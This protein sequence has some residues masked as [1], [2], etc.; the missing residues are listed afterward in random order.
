[1]SW[2]LS[3]RVGGELAFEA[4]I[5]DLYDR[6]FSDMLIGFFFDG[7]DKERLIKS[8]MAYLSA[9]LGDR[10]GTYAGP[11]IRRAHESLAILPGH[12]DRRH[13]LLR[14]V[15]KVH[16]VPNDVQEAWLAFDQSLRPFVI[17]EGKKAVDQR[18]P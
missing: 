3:E 11:S 16:D 15:L 17:R 9:H 13:H 12:F 14:E 8:Q 2:N 5:R 6:M 18:Y 7:K 10:A 1:M 4:T